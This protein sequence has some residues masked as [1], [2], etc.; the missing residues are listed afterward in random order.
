MAADQSNLNIVTAFTHG[1][2]SSHGIIKS[3]KAGSELLSL[4]K[5]VKMLDVRGIT[6]T[7]DALH[8]RSKTCELTVQEGGDYCLQLKANQ[9]EI[10]E[11][12]HA[13]VND[14]NVEY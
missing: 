8:C 4:C 2:R 11:N 12:T 1:I 14:E 9:K 7:A 3:G 6:I 10:L 5:L 13:L